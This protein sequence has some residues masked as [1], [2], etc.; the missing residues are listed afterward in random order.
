MPSMRRK[1]NNRH[2]PSLS[3]DNEACHSSFLTLYYCLAYFRFKLGLKTLRK[4]KQISRWTLISGWYELFSKWENYYL[5]QR[6]PK[7]DSVPLAR[8]CKSRKCHR[9]SALNRC[10]GWRRKTAGWSAWR[11]SVR[12]CTWQGTFQL[13]STW[14]RSQWVDDELFP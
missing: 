7:A 9:I 12:D 8:V 6:G 14:P 3:T 10:N 4:L 13:K 11:R 1:L 5:D 2:A